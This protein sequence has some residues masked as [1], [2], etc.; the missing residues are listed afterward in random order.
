MKCYNSGNEYDPQINASG[1]VVWRGYDDTDYE[2]FL[3]ENSA[4]DADGIGNLNDNCP[5]ICN[6][7]QQDSDG[8]GEGDVCDAT[9]G[10]GGCGEPVCET[11]C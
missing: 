2:I 1:Q 7:S 11:E 4:F 9:P 3:A 5:T 6:S 8:D 10:C